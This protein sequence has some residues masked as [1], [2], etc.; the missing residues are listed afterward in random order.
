MPASYKSLLFF[1]AGLIV[2]AVALV[3]GAFSAMPT[4]WPIAAW[5]EP[6]L[7]FLA[8]M[9]CV[10]VVATVAAFW[11][12]MRVIAKAGVANAKAETWEKVVAFL[13][14]L[15]GLAAA[16]QM[17]KLAWIAQGVAAF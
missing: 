3:V 13:P 8:W 17:I 15:P 12:Q 7:S 2:T 5:K 10:I 11:L 14:V 9:S 1:L 4:A 16:W 6:L